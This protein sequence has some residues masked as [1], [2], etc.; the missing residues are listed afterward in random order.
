MNIVNKKNKVLTLL[1][2]ILV[3]ALVLPACSND[4]GT[5]NQGGGSSF[6][7]V[8]KVDPSKPYVYDGNF[9]TENLGEKY[10][11]SMNPP[12]PVVLSFPVINI[13]SEYA[14]LLNGEIQHNMGIALDI[15]DECIREK[16]YFYTDASFEYYEHG[17][18]LSVV[19]KQVFYGSI[20][21]TPSYYTY[22]IDLETGDYYETKDFV[23]DLG[24]GTME[25]FRA[26]CREAIV[27]KSLKKKNSGDPAYEDFYRADLGANLHMFYEDFSY[28]LNQFYIDGSGTINLV[29]TMMDS[30]SSI[31]AFKEV[32]PIKKGKAKEMEINPA[33]KKLGLK[34][35]SSFA[36]A[37]VGFRGSF[38]DL[39]TMEKTFAFLE[40]YGDGFKD[41]SMLGVLNEE[42]NIWGDEVYLIIPKYKNS[43][44]RVKPL[45]RFE[46]GTTTY[47][48]SQVNDF[49]GNTL[50]SCNISDLYTD[51]E[52]EI[53]DPHG[54]FIFNPSISLMDGSLYLETNYEI[55]G[56]FD[57]TD[58]LKNI[59]KPTK[60]I[61]IEFENLYFCNILDA[62]G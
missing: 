38:N 45:V 7:P 53:V 46:D 57:F 9:D 16:D 43:V 6:T 55:L 18:V 21:P 5:K 14:Q 1:T 54:N 59:K 2:L 12:V 35:D 39:E 11:K 26:S 61:P 56:A 4:P 32:M 15:L 34:D 62:K 22:N 30:P 8:A 31:G 24:Y 3:V 36:V 23:E 29:M 25:D 37:Y 20:V 48:D 17:K 28:E 10:T 49:V 60:K 41:I 58:M 13:D 33:Y 42:L 27:E 51:C 50:I 44:V 52:I 47:Y 40:K 19:I